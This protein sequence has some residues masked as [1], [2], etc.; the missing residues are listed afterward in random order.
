MRITW[1]PNKADANQRKHGVNL[2]EVEAV[3]HDPLS[4]ITEDLSSIDEQR[5]LVLGVGDA[6][7]IYVVVYTYQENQIRLISARKASKAET[8]YYEKGIRF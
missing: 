8:K 2:S 5:F 7:R 1:N 3:L 6:N 4:I